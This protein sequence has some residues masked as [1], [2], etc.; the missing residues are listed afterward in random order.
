MI[1]CHTFFAVILN[2][3]ILTVMKLFLLSFTVI[4]RSLPLFVIISN[5]SDRFISGSTALLEV[6]KYLKIPLSISPTDKIH[7]QPIS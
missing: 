2:F 7:E 6:Y 5:L 3:P 1:F 4:H